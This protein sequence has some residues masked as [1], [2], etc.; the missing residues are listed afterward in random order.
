[1]STLRCT[2]AIVDLLRRTIDEHR[3]L[4][5]SPLSPERR[6]HA[7]QEPAPDVSLAPVASFFALAFALS[8]AWWLVLLAGGD[9]VRRGEGW[10]THIPGM[11]GPLLAAL[12]V[13]AGTEGRAGVRRWLAGMTRVPRE[14][15]WQLAS[16][17]PLGFAAVGVALAAAFSELPSAREFI[18]FSGVAADAGLFALVLLV[19]AFGEEAG[20]RGYALPRLQRRLGPLR[21]TLVLALLWALWHAPLFILLDSYQGFGPPAAVGF[22][23]GLTAGALVLTALYNHTG[24]SILAVAVWHA[25]Y[26]LSAATAAADG[27]VAAVS[28][29]CVIAWAISLVHREAAGR[30]ARGGSPP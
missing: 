15:R 7:A 21:A 3:R 29:A 9:R 6:P 11:M 13:L 28:T 1:M 2:T 17:A 18:S 19:S 23:I 16:V 22:L 12:I 24:G 26:N 30:P 27:T 20:W 25:S 5:R 4:D 14:R 8:W 10:P